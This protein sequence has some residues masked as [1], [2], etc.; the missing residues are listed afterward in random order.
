MKPFFDAWPWLSG[1]PRVICEAQGLG[2]GDHQ[3][4]CDHHS[5]NIYGTPTGCQVV[6]HIPTYL[7]Y[8]FLPPTAR[9]GF[10]SIPQRGGPQPMEPSLPQG[11]KQS[12]LARIHSTDPTHRAKLLPLGA[13]LGSSGGSRPSKCAVFILRIKKER[14]K[15]KQMQDSNRLSLK[16]CDSCYVTLGKSCFFPGRQFS[17]LQ[18]ERTTPGEPP[19]IHFLSAP[20]L[21]VIL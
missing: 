5:A 10:S 3:C 15:S 7:L 14:L 6:L 19:Q 9:W 1:K 8:L 2:S 17:G 18:N 20:D 21:Y 13:T 16:P 4:F 11:Q 12:P